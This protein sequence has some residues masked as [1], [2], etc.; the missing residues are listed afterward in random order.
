MG[1]IIPSFLILN[2][3]IYIY[4]SERKKAYSYSPEARKEIPRLHAGGCCD[5]RSAT[6]LD[7][8]SF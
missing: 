3:H 6:Y 5:V 4:Y 7:P 2:Y 1:N 8:T